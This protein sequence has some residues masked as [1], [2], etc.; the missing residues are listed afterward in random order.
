MK[1]NFTILILWCLL[2]ASCGLLG[3]ERTAAKLVTRADAEKIMGF[4]MK[5]DQEKFA[6]KQSTCIYTN[7]GGDSSRHLQ[8]TIQEYLSDDQAKDAHESM[9][10]MNR[11]YV[12]IQPVEGVGDAA[13]VETREFSQAIHVRRKNVAFLIVADG[14]EN[15]EQ[16]LSGL[17]RVAE[18]VAA[19]L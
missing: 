16:K 6:E 8:I 5:L 2:T 4:P 18:S 13:W 14:T 7:A 15:G 11:R 1:R 12:E 9:Q 3:G 19:R 17:R 10:E